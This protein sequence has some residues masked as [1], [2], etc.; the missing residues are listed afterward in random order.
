MS[1]VVCFTGRRP[2]D[3]CGYDRECYLEFN[4]QLVKFVKKLYDDGVRTFITGGAQGFDQLAFWAVNKLKTK[5]DDITNIVY[6]PYKGQEKMWAKI[7]VFSQDDYK[8][9]LEKADEV[10]YLQGYCVENWS[11][12]LMDRNHK[13]VDDSDFVVALYQGDD[14]ASAKGGTAE[15]MRYANRHNKQIIQLNYR[16]EDGD[17]LI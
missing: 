12:A 2:K 16:I 9:M 4:N 13:M 8:Q 6:V 11:K 3:L 17:L 5:Y 15:C 1:K 14:W 10:K 7:G